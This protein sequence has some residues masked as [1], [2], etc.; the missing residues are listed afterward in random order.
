VGEQGLHRKSARGVIVNVEDVERIVI[1]GTMD[2]GNKQSGGV[3]FRAKTRTTN[4]VV[5]LFHCSSSAAGIGF[6][7]ERAKCICNEPPESAC[8]SANLKNGHQ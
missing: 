2:Q 5:R 7:D 1:N 4:R 3:I 8:I 6:F